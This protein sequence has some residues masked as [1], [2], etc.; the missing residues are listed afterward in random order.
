MIKDARSDPWVD[1]FLGIGIAVRRPLADLVRPKSLRWPLNF[2]FQVG[3]VG[4]ESRFS[5][6]LVSMDKGV[7]FWPLAMNLHGLRPKIPVVSFS[8]IQVYLLRDSPIYLLRLH[9]YCSSGPSET[10]LHVNSLAYE[11]TPERQRGPL[12]G[13]G[14]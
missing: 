7:F 1:Y 6:P 4:G 5:W 14:P 12:R 8:V 11:E 13:H 3:G 10:M 2:C 9:F